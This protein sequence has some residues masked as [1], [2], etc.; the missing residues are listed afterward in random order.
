MSR[1]KMKM[2]VSNLNSVLEMD[3]PHLIFTEH[4][5]TVYFTRITFKFIEN[6]VGS[7]LHNDS[8][9]S[10]QAPVSERL[11]KVSQ[12]ICLR[13]DSRLLFCLNGP[14]DQQNFRFWSDTNHYKNVIASAFSQQCWSKSTIYY[15]AAE[16]S[17]PA[18]LGFNGF[19]P[20]V[21]ECHSTNDWLGSVQAYLPKKKIFL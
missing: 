10:S 5:P 18:L 19:F 15:I 6:V 20:D 2:L 4:F 1:K 16:N 11:F 17:T 12:T 14:A 3:L 8:M 9:S 21:T 13:R 7:W